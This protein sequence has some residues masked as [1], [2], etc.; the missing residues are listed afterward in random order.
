MYNPE[1]T[2]SADGDDNLRKIRDL[3]NWADAFVLGSPDYNGSISG[4]LKN[5]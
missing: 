5:F 4:V 2:V 3:L 1:A